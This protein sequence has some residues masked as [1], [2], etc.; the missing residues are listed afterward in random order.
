ME[1]TFLTTD[2]FLNHGR[3]SFAGKGSKEIKRAGVFVG[4]VKRDWDEKKI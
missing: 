3:K 2:L 1:G 4:V